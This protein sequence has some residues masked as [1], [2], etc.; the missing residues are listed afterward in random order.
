MQLVIMGVSGSGKSVVGTE[1]AQRL[2][3]A[4]HDADDFHPES[5]IS[6]MSAGIPLDDN[7]RVPWLK[8][9]ANCISEY[10]NQGNSCVIACSALK[11]SYRDIL[12][13]SSSVVFVFLKG[14]PETILPRVQAREDHF[15]PAALLESQFSVLEAPTDA[16]EV[17]INCSVR[18]I[19]DSILK[20]LEA[21]S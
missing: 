17:E 7:D 11:K 16:I 10:E 13:V 14:S 19:V 20:K 4:F 2:G 15:M 3:Y 21:G 12:R 5:N 18:E 1:L 9:I 8:E 6:K